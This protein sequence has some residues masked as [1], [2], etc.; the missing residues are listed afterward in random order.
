MTF[1][2]RIVKITAEKGRGTNMPLTERKLSEAM[3]A[4]IAGYIAQNYIDACDETCGAVEPVRVKKLACEREAE[5]TQAPQPAMMQM[6]AVGA[7]T[8]EEALKAED[9]GFSEAVLKLIDATGKKDS[10]IYKKANLSKQ[11]FSKIRN[12]PSYNPS[13]PTAVALALALELDLEQTQK[14]IG[15]AGYTLTNSS[16][17]DLIIMFFIEQKIYNIVEINLALYE[18]DQALLGV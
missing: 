10:E 6:A 7:R 5:R 18:F 2:N 4:Q 9:I 1:G 15:R 13:K 16:K 11:H 17:F 14:L 8:L 3:L 12:N